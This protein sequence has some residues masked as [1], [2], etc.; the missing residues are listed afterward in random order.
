MS[1]AISIGRNPDARRS[2]CRRLQRREAATNPRPFRHGPAQRVDEE[3]LFRD[4]CIQQRI[5]LEFKFLEVGENAGRS[6]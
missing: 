5:G 1:A 4:T 6:H 2:T 3:H